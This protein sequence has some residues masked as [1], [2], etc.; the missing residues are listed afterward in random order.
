MTFFLCNF[1]RNICVLLYMYETYRHKLIYLKSYV[2]LIKYDSVAEAK[3]KKKV[4]SYD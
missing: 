3:A 1:Y 4:S 2:K